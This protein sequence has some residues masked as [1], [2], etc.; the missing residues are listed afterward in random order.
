MGF[1][2]TQSINEKVSCDEPG[3]REKAR[4]GSSDVLY[5]RE[6]IVHLISN[7]ESSKDSKE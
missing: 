6:F 1:A 2:R 3:Q 5:T 4:P 7:M